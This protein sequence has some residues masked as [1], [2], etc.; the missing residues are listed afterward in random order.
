MRVVDCAG[1]SR[2][3]GRAHGETLRDLI[4][5]AEAVGELSVIASSAPAST[6]TVTAVFGNANNLDATHGKH[7][8]QPF[9]V[10]GV[11]I[12]EEDTQPPQLNFGIERQATGHG[13]EYLGAFTW[14][15]ANL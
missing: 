6:S 9:T 10:E 11:I 12:G 5:D 3:R 2:T 8:A 13:Y 14:G 1:T 7:V 4:A 15:R